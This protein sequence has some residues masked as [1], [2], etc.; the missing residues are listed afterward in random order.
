MLVRMKVQVSGSRNGVAWPPAETEIEVPYPEGRDLILAELA[1]PVDEKTAEELAEQPTAGH[2]SK[3]DARPPSQIEGEK[4]AA[5]AA[6]EQGDPAAE[7]S[8]ELPS[9]APDV[10]GQDE[11]GGEGNA[12][13]GTAE[14]SPAA[15][16]PGPSAP[17]QAWIDYAVNAHG[18]D[19]QAASAMTKAD[20]MSRYGGR[21]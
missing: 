6:A 2:P 19:V 8:G 12:G 18:A 21:L 3:L 5:Q 10:A 13:D 11:A 15:G 9:L 20:L 14:S 16:A 1:E 4:L 7:P 17:K